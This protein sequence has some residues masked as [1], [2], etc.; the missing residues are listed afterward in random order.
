MPVGGLA[1]SSRRYSTSQHGLELIDCGFEF[2]L[3]FVGERLL[4]EADV[5]EGLGEELYRIKGFSGEE[6]E[7]VAELL[8]CEMCGADDSVALEDFHQAVVEAK[9]HREAE[10]LGGWERFKAYASGAAAHADSLEGA[11][12]VEHDC[13]EGGDGD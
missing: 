7:G 1:A 11:A 2:L 6:G 4:A 5:V 3:L 10:L 12:G 13:D 8:G 9:L